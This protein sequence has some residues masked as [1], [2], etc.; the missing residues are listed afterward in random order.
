MKKYTICLALLASS[1]LLTG[2]D[3]DRI[4]DEAPAF[5]RMPWQEEVEE[6]VWGQEVQDSVNPK[7]SSAP[8][9]DTGRMDKA[10]LASKYVAMFYK[11]IQSGDYET[12]LAMQQMPTD[13][14]KGVDYQSWYELSG[15][16]QYKDFDITQAETISEYDDDLASVTFEWTYKEDDKKVVKTFE[17]QVRMTDE[18]FS[19]VPR[20]D[21][22]YTNRTM[23]LPGEVKVINGQDFS[24]YMVSADTSYT[25]MVFDYFPKG[26]FG[27]DY[28][29]RWGH[30]A[31]TV[32]PSSDGDFTIRQTVHE[33]R[34]RQMFIQAA[35][36][37]VNKLWHALWDDRS[38][39]AMLKI[40][41]NEEKVDQLLYQLP[42]IKDKTITFVEVQS[43]L[44]ENSEVT[45]YIFAGDMVHLN[46]KYHTKFDISTNGMPVSMSSCKDFTWI[47]LQ[48]HEDGSWVI[49]DMGI[50]KD[51]SILTYLDYTN[52]EW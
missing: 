32:T 45:D 41:L 5:P 17:A 13:I 14:L 1:L 10:P 40:F 3:M 21:G 23:V 26:S 24:R 49:V 30:F 4:L 34:Q 2:C 29:T 37:C 6:Y 18:G 7:L 25:T 43:S 50:D 22:F 38:K 44:D 27:I 31:S 42:D 35:N 15:Y 36:E 9:I 12:F 11:A 39:E 48:Q 20:T 8:E 52:N 51:Q 28:I 46:I 47:D 16:S 19:I 33:E